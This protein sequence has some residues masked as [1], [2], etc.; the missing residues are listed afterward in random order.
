MK[1][2]LFF[3][4][5]FFAVFFPSFIALAIMGAPLVPKSAA[6][7]AA[8][9]AEQVVMLVREGE[10]PVRIVI[11]SVGI[12]TLVQNP[13]SA[14]LSV[15]DAA[16]SRGAV[17]YPLSGELGGDKNIFLFG[18]S[19]FLPQVRNPAY[20]A[21]N[22]LEKVKLGETIEVRSVSRT[23]TYRV[24][25]VAKAEAQAL[26]IDLE[27]PTGLLFLSTCNSFGDKDERFV[28]TAQ[29]VKSS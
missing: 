7:E 22:K 5:A 21:F 15:L 3:S 20:Q 19:S 14:E 18:H 13:E 16:L 27:H 10:L 2:P 11:N 9:S 12:N 26:S 4:A 29:F 17:R 28:V 1:K 24:I 8:V 23:Y 6:A 25:S